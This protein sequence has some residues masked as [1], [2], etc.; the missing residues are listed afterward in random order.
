V[1]LYSAISGFTSFFHSLKSIPT[2]YYARIMTI[3]LIEASEEHL[4]AIARIATSAFNPDTDALSRR[5]FPLHLQPKDLPDGEAAYD[6][7]FARKASSLA[8]SESHLVVAVDDEKGPDD[9][10]VGFSLWDAPPAS[11]GDSAPSREIQ[12]AALDKEAF[13]EMKKTVNQDAVDNFGEKGINGVW[14]TFPTQLP[15]LP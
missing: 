14:R 8:S 6:W 11:G 5:L 13:N 2:L 1:D 9:H 12:C 4:P 15:P 7:R 3:R 10:I